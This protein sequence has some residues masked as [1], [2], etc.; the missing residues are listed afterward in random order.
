MKVKAKL[1]SYAWSVQTI[2][3][4][5]AELDQVI[6]R[7]LD[8][9]L[10]PGG[11]WHQFVCPEHHTELV[12]DPLE[13]DGSTFRCPHGCEWGGEPYR[14]AWLV[15]K[16]QAMARYALQSA[17]VYA[18]TG[19]K[20]YAD[21]GKR[22]IVRYAEQFPLYPVHPD[23]QPW[24]LKGRAFHQ[25]LTEAIWATTLL[26]GYLLLRDED[27]WFDEADIR[28]IDR[29][30][31][32]LESSMTEYHHILSR[33]RGNP[34]NNYTAWLIAA[35]FCIYAVQGDTKKLKRLVEQEGGLR[36][37]LTIAVK[38]DQLEFEG[39]IYYHVFVLRA[40]LIAAEMGSRVGEELFSLRG[41]QGQCMQGMLSVLVR[42]SDP[43]GFLPALHDGPYRRVPFAREIA[44]IAE[45]GLSVYGDKSYRRLLGH[46]YRELNGEAGR[47][48]M[49]EALLYGTG[50]WEGRIGMAAPG[51][52]GSHNLK[53]GEIWETGDVIEVQVTREVPRPGD[54]M[55]ADRDLTAHEAGGI[56]G[57]TVNHAVGESPYSVFLPHSG[58]ALL[59]TNDPQGLQA[60]I[61]FGPHGGSHGHF[62]KLNLMIHAGDQPLSPDRGTVP[63]GSVL[64]KEWYPHTACHNTVSVGGRS[65]N[66]AEG[67]CM[68]Y[69]SAPNRSY[70]WVRTD[71]AY[72][73]G[74]LDR[75]LI[76]AEDWLLDWF[77]VDL[78][79]PA[80]VDWWF[81][82]VGTGLLREGSGEVQHSGSAEP[83]NEDGH[84]YVKERS[85]NVWSRDG[86]QVD[87][88]IAN[89]SGALAVASFAT[90]EGTVC[91]RV[92]SP[93]LAD[94]PSRPMEGI[95]LHRLDSK[96]RFIVVYRAGNEPISLG[97]TYAADGDWLQL[98]DGRTTRSFTMT[99]NG[100]KERVLDENLV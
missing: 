50:S 41:E 62:D 70:I 53:T 78:D 16:H 98:S 81:H 91:S 58:F 38:P 80:A 31:H 60:L 34:E 77:E 40:Y 68:R 17:A 96:A 94:D 86:M 45:I 13:A 30:L 57:G 14:G 73:H 63:Y 4:L 21:L 85:S 75:H 20:G 2:D 74:I 18:G 64:K 71:E 65:Q 19:E 46:A 24:M 69:E 5:K 25:A 51:M 79:E 47:I 82:Y 66:P 95:R 1:N 92:E 29:F 11:W 8:V 54:A 42:L 27:V 87:L 76:M 90:F 99:N 36:H 61:D 6:D 33:E 84:A 28:K 22:L 48:G 26:R 44:E 39:S 37:H 3:I 12:F 56:E 35:L 88:H 59:R 9:P 15:F 83:G 67:K 89:E 93:G 43:D 23:A 55:Q 10:E 72:D 49:L 97:W 7:R 32:M 52:R 100:L